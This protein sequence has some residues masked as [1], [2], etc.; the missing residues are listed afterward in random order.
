MICPKR[1]Q[2]AWLEEHCSDKEVR[3]SVAALL[4]RDRDNHLP[5][6]IRRRRFPPRPL[7]RI[8]PWNG[9]VEE[10]RAAF[11]A[12]SAPPVNSDKPLRLRSSRRSL[13]RRRFG[14]ALRRSVNCWRCWIIRIFL[15]CWML[16]LRR[17]AIRTLRLQYV[18]GERLDS[19]CDARKLGVRE[20]L[21]LFLQIT[22]AVEYAHKKG[23][24]HRDL[25]P[26]N[27]LVTADG[28]VKLLDFGTGA[29]LST[30]PDST[31]TRSRMVTPRYASPERLRGEPA[32]IAND[33]F[34]LGIV[35]YELLTGIWPFGNVAA[36]DEWQRSHTDAAPLDPPSVVLEAA[37]EVRSMSVTQLSRTLA[38]DLSA[39]LLKALES[40][41]SRR[42][43]SV[44]QLSA[45]IR[46]YLEERPISAR[47]PTVF[48]KAGK[49]VRKHSIPVAALFSIVALTAYIALR[50]EPTIKN[51]SSIS[52]MPFK[53]VG[54]PNEQY[55][56]DG[57]ADS[58]REAL[59]RNR[60][61]L[62]IG[63]ASALAL[64][65]KSAKEVGSTLNVNS[66]LSGEISK[67]GGRV[68]LVARILRTQDGEQMWSGVFDR[69]LKDSGAIV[70]DVAAAVAG[71]LRAV[72]GIP[73]FEH[74][75]N[76]EATEWIMRA[77]YES[78]GFSSA[79]LAGV[80]S[81]CRKAIEIDP[82]MATAYMCLANTIS[83]R[84]VAYFRDPTT[85][86]MEEL[87]KLVKRALTLDPLV[88]GGHALLGRIALQFRWD[89]D[90]AEREL[91]LATAGPPNATSES[92]MAALLVQRGRFTEAQPH[93]ERAL[94]FDPYG[95]VTLNNITN[96]VFWT[97]RT[98]E[99]IQLAKRYHEVAPNS[100]QA[101]MMFLESEVWAGHADQT[102]PAYAKLRQKFPGPGA[103]F[104]AWSRA[105][106]GQKEE[107]L[108]LLRPLEDAYPKAGLP[109]AGIARAYAYMGD[110]PNT[111]KWLE[112]VC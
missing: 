42:Y 70:S 21:R 55:Y 32:N 17:Q 62:V 37:A 107:A 85:E 12:V 64:K 38:G 50:T 57:M 87:E 29:L 23:I 34:S 96:T 77:R 60:L 7:V 39:I 33:V 56:V 4:K 88:P 28:Q 58:F 76:P 92:I 68:H 36:A 15:I 18:E 104:E 30:A 102:W 74:Q 19:Y 1:E 9:L 45:D 52:V 71:N 69:T 95:A 110:E 106:V 84:W 109:L 13:T 48:Y 78:Q 103:L 98:N 79:A 3:R 83:D 112:R 40:D 94:R 41:T 43:S 26:G 91:S 27:I 20:R 25:K 111:V 82:Q 89:W 90:T 61:L 24:V 5:K 47:S 10:E 108:K 86:E 101:Q 54:D 93:I 14:N 49:F 63:K 100:I 8:A 80:E 2:L 51:P 35:L 31:V 73:R 22:D 72:A 66:V 81:D 11:I 53:N 44:A 97:G 65:D 6:R 105:I 75:A 46:A 99:A 59:S 16:T 67:S